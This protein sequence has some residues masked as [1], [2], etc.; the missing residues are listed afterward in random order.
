[1]I[2]ER[3][4]CIK[5][6]KIVERPYQTR[7][8]NFKMTL[9]FTNFHHFPHPPHITTTTITPH[10]YYTHNHNTTPIQTH[11]HIPT[12]L[13]PPIL[14]QHP[15]HSSTHTNTTPTIIYPTHHTLTIIIYHI[16]PHLL[17]VYYNILYTQIQTH[18]I[19]TTN[20]ILRP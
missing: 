9:N 15:Q 12:I 3:G 13:P 20:I 10:P 8:S 17:W 11:H 4:F 5:I 1:M 2:Y 6:Q 18:L 7:F 16:I 14:Y 19:T